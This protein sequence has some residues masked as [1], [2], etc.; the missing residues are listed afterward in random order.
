MKMH[1]N[2][3]FEY[4]DD[5]DKLRR[6]INAEVMYETLRW[7]DAEIKDNADMESILEKISNTFKL[8]GES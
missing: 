7:I 1:A 2:L 3:S 4:P 6:A 5:E 8:I